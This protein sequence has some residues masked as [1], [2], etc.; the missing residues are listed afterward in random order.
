MTVLASTLVVRKNCIWNLER[1]DSD[2]LKNCEI[3]VAGNWGNQAFP[4][5]PMQLKKF[6]F[7]FTIF[8]FTI[9][10]FYQIAH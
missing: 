1:L 2:V 9:F 10:K 3:C 7:K 5:I 4:E 6:E 8:K